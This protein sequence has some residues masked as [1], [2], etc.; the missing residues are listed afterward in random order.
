MIVSYDRRFMFI[1]I[2]KT[3]GSS[4]RL[5]MGEFADKPRELWPNRLLRMAGVDVNHV[6]PYRKRMLHRHVFARKVQLH[7]PRRV[8]DG[9]FK[10]A[11]V[12][13]PWDRMV[14]W[15][16]YILSRPSHRRHRRVRRLGS[17]EAY[18]HDE[19][20]QD[21]VR[22]LPFLVDARGELIVDFVGRFESLQAEF[23]H[24]CR[25]IGICARLPHRK[26]SPPYDYRTYYSD[27]LIELL[28][29]HVR[30]EIARFGYTFDSPLRRA[31]A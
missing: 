18:L 7:I 1:H 14:C 19:I 8:F 23:L 28:A 30:E 26:P 16:H 4:I 22:Q 27:A 10:F 24:V 21:R 15:Y 2:P 11:F 29:D 9:L 17:F 20:R 3:A 31:A 13:N 12:R 6:A 5:A 25:T